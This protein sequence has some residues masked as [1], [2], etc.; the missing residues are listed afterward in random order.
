MKLV[1]FFTALTESMDF[2]A[3]TLEKRE[4]GLT[5]SN[6]VIGDYGSEMELNVSNGNAFSIMKE[7]GYVMDDYS[8]T[9]PID[10]F[11]A[12]TTQWLQKNIG[13]RSAEV[14]TTV[15]KTPGRATFYDMGKREGYF[16]EKIMQMNKMARE[17]MRK[18]ATHVWMA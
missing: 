1:E 11:I 18:G 7:L 2:Y 12:V 9:V 16:N 10:E 17:G 8:I 5:Y 4:D 15:D 14:P 3:G 6:S 13:K